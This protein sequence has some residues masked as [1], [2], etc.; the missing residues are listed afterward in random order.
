MEKMRR[1][2]S[3]GIILIMA[4]AAIFVSAPAEA[5]KIA[6]AAETSD[7]QNKAIFI[8]P[9]IWRADS[10]ASYSFKGAALENADLATDG[11]VRSYDTSNGTVELPNPYK[12]DGSVTGLSA[13]WSF[14]G[15]VTL[16]V[17]ITGS[18]KDYVEVINGVPVT[19]KEP[20]AGSGIKWRATLAPNSTLTDLKI[21]Y[22]DLSG[23]VGS[24]GE[25]LLSGFGARKWIYVKGSA[26]GTLFNYQMPIRVGE[27]QKS[28]GT[29]DFKLS[30]GILSDFA[31]I[32]FTATDGETILPHYLESVT[33]KAPNRTAVF[34]VNIPEIPKNGLPIY[35]YYSKTGAS[36]LSSGEK[37]FDF[38]DDFGGALLNGKKWKT[39]LYDK[40]G[41]ASVKDSI[42]SLTR[43]KITSADY[44]FASGLIEYK[45]R[46][47]AS[48]SSEGIIRATSSGNDDVIAYSSV[49]SSASAH[50][51]TKGSG[52]KANDPKPISP[53]AFYT[54]KIYCDDNGDIA[55]RRYGEDGSG[56]AQAETEYLAGSSEASPIGLSSSI[57]G[58]TM[59]CDWIRTRKAANPPPQ[60][61]TRTASMAPEATNL[62]E[63]YNVSIAPD[64]GLI[65]SS[66]SSESYYI[67]RLISPAFDARIIKP[68][69][70]V[71][72]SDEESVSISIAVKNGGKFYSD[73]KNG[74]ARYASKKEFDK[75][76][77]LRWKAEFGSEGIEL[78]KFSL[79]YRP[80]TI[81]VVM[82]KGG[83]TLT[84]GAS[85]SIFWEAAGYD[86]KYPLEISYSKDD[87]ED[88][89]VIAAKVD[90]SGDYA[91]NV[92][93][94]VSGKAVMKVADYNDKSIYGISEDYFSI[95]SGVTAETKVRAAEEVGV[96]ESV[97]PAEEKPAETPKA[98]EKP[99]AGMYDL[100]IKVGDNPSPDGYKDGDIVMVKPAGYLWGAEERGKFLIVRTYLTPQRALELMQP[101]E[102]VTLTGKSNRKVTKTLNKRKYRFNLQD[103]I[104][105][106][107]RAK[108]AQGHL[109]GNALEVKDI[110]AE[111]EKK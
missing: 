29:C 91:W 42:L 108:A 15:K 10:S 4:M 111:T 43:A 6:E 98:V 76:S 55:F 107:E 73:W 35:M 41:S 39:V 52:T 46:A 80:G 13:S 105:L 56:T 53:D 58:E 40:A 17:S 64:G 45:A 22:S 2:L 7:A 72:L 44:K 19:Y 31:D 12:T 61:D 20:Y 59:S 95:V 30:G 75:G 21:T 9:L 51:I 26:A 60:V 24:F 28:V 87:S 85:Y 3:I 48:G 65:P 11:S 34:W 67:S 94:G 79:E 14:T 47:S 103:K 50:S 96:I 93:A 106:Q 97:T 32:R 54:Y 1:F 49:S 16:E 38:F 104:T 33:G 88:F 63:F 71:D 109:T 69:W 5:A 74:A 23:V 78:K 57:I 101:D 18:S 27:S 102:M 36:D 99:L 92:P 25:S 90:N 8:R 66:D 68:S 89:E 77:Q 37:V 84:S 86:P 70:D 62:P 83:E 100:L 81:R 82:P 110:A